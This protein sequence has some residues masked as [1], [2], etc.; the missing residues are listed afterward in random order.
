MAGATAKGPVGVAAEGGVRAGEERLGAKGPQA[1]GSHLTVV[2]A[3][4]GRRHR[5][6][7]P[8]RGVGDGVCVAGGLARVLPRVVVEYLAVGANDLDSHVGGHG[9]GVL[10]LSKDGA[11]P[12][13]LALVDGGDALRRGVCQGLHVLARV[14]LELTLPHNAQNG[15][16]HGRGH[17]CRQG[18]GQGHARRVGLGPLGVRL[19]GVPR[20]ARRGL[21]GAPVC[22]CVPACYELGRQGG[23]P[24]LRSTWRQRASR[25]PRSDIPRRGRCRASAGC[26]GR[27]QAWRAGS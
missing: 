21:L 10:G 26:A 9:A 5:G 19:D 12:G 17:D 11:V 3:K 1:Q 2:C 25:E 13:A 18:K 20:I 24:R 15:N 16:E 23:P 27:R 6:V 14:R 7:R 4:D 22:A 8:G